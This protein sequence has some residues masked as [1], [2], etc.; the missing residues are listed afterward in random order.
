VISETP[1]PGCVI[2]FG[3]E[4]TDA[5]GTI[6]RYEWD[7]TADGSVDETTT[8][9]I[10]S[11]TYETPG[12]HTVRLTVTDNDGQ[13]D[14]TTATFTLHFPDREGT[15]CQPD[16]TARA[17]SVRPPSTWKLFA[18]PSGSLRKGRLV[19]RLNATVMP[20][21]AVSA[22]PDPRPS[23]AVRRL[24]AARWTLTPLARGRFAGVARIR[25]RHACLRADVA[26]GSF[27]ATD[28]ALRLT[29]RFALR[30]SRLG[31]TLRV[32]ARRR[33]AGARR[34]ASCRVP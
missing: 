11:H 10:L 1:R 33:A 8:D 14:S 20:P 17:A 15:L 7:W 30:R 25:G 21:G 31:G 22:G 9:S 27:T 4:S 13:S 28:G 29:G 26:K 23:R 5:D 18:R 12:P 19:G 16:R 6:T 34:R 2:A 24:L 32:S 3:S